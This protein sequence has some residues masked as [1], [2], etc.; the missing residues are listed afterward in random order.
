MVGAKKLRVR[1]RDCGE[2]APST[3]QDGTRQDPLD[4]R[5]LEEMLLGVSTR[6]YARSLEPLPPGVGSVAVSRSS[7]WR[8][9]VART[10]EKVEEFL[11]RPPET[12][13]HLLTIDG[14]AVGRTCSWWRWTL[15]AAARS[16]RCFVT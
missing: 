11:L 5:G 15:T 8:R 1:A 9:F 10:A 7:V 2:I 12:D 4:E 6:K 3:W 13:L 16:K 14:R